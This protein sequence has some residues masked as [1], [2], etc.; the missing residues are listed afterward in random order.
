MKCRGLDVKTE[1]HRKVYI[2][3][4]R[5][6]LLSTGKKSATGG[7]ICL[8]C[9]LQDFSDCLEQSCLQMFTPIYQQFFSRILSINQDDTRYYML[10]ILAWLE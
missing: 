2:C 4:K 10:K 8:F 3:E 9:N 6:I 5:L 7:K 1:C